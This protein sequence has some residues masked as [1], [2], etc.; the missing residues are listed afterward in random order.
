[1]AALVVLYFY[2]KAAVYP[3][4]VVC[5]IALEVSRLGTMPMADTLATNYC[6]KL[7]VTMVLLEEWA[8]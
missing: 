2:Y 3:A 1:M 8:H 6:H 7:V 4:I 5:A